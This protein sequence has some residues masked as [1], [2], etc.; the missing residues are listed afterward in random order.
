MMASKLTRRAFVKGAAALVGSL[1]FLKMGPASA[2]PP[3]LTF[4]YLRA[5]KDHFAIRDMGTF[6]I[7]PR[8]G[9]G[10]RT[11]GSIK[12]SG[13]T[14]TKLYDVCVELLKQDAQRQF[15]I[16]NSK[17]EYSRYLIA[18][19]P[20]SIASWWESI[21]RNGVYR[22]QMELLDRG[23]VVASAIRTFTVIGGTP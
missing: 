7:S 3:V 14:T 20:G 16:V 5:Y 12:V 19:Q 17:A 15:S 11:E 8:V 13:V 23:T 10:N 2:D 6:D 18:R 21:H 9:H 4:Q 22:Y 1:P